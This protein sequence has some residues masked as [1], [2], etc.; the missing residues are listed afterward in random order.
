M[1]ESGTKFAGALTILLAMNAKVSDIKTFYINI[2]L[3]KCSSCSETGLYKTE[4]NSLTTCLH[5]LYSADQLSCNVHYCHKILYPDHV[6]QKP[7]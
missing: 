4:R 7:T 1:M 3:N 6:T 5:Y 2:I